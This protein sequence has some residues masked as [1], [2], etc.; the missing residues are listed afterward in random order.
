M[1][2]LLKPSARGDTLSKLIGSFPGKGGV[3]EGQQEQEQE[4]VAESH[5]FRMRGIQRKLKGC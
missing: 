5:Y 1:Q 3:K 4:K 2:L